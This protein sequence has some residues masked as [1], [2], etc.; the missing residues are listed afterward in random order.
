MG[1]GGPVPQ[2]V[3][4]L[5]EGAEVFY[6]GLSVDHGVGGEVAFPHPPF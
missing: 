6:S 2:S 5:G 3:G 4:T 1:G